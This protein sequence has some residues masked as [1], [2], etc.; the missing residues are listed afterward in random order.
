M[1]RAE[2]PARGHATACPACGGALSPPI[3]GAVHCYVECTVCHAR[4]ELDDPELALPC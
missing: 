1:T 4:F 3:S 2:E